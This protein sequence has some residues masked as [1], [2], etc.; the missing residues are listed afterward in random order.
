MRED[1]LAHSIFILVV[2]S[3]FNQLRKAAQEAK[4]KLVDAVDESQT[5]QFQCPICH[6]RFANPEILIQHHASHENAAIETGAPMPPSPPR[7]EPTQPTKSDFYKMKEENSQ[8]SQQLYLMSDQIAISTEQKKLLDDKLNAQK[9]EP[10]VLKSNSKKK[11]VKI[12]NLEKSNED[13][14][15]KISM[16]NEEIQNNQIENKNHQSKAMKNSER[17][18]SEILRLQKE[19][20]ENLRNFEDLKTKCG[21][22]DSDLIRLATEAEERLKEVTES[23]N[24]LGVKLQK[25]SERCEVLER[26]RL[27]IYNSVLSAAD[28]D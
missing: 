10:K 5:G 4:N 1:F 21:Q 8:L 9:Y 13:Y 27:K 2:F 20:D 6:K 28:F 18:E 24:D 25:I 19:L 15:T 12:E 3:M 23:K 14:Q 7:P 16:L 26:K 17:L 11:T 22:D